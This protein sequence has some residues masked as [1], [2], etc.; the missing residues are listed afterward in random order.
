MRNIMLIAPLLL[1]TGCSHTANDSWS[2]QDQSP[3]LP[4]LGN[5]F[6][7]SV[8]NMPSIKGYSRDRAALLARCFP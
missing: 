1:L 7:P 4:R 6:R 8:T 3:A 2:G 5:A